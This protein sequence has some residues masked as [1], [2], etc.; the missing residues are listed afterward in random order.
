M[1]GLLTSTDYAEGIRTTM[2]AGG[3]NASRS[4]FIGACLAARNGVETIPSDWTTKTLCY[5]K[6]WE[7][8]QQ[9]VELRREI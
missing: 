1:H 6:A 4:A 8:C 2:H 5:K 7:L 3:C 9:L